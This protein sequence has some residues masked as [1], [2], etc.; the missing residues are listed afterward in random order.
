MRSKKLDFSDDVIQRAIEIAEE[1]RSKQTKPKIR[2]LSPYW[3]A[4][5]WSL[6]QLNLD[7]QKEAIEIQN[8][9]EL[10]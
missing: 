5:N 8:Q 9:L 10:F 1:M 4:D 2:H 7:W 3:A 6:E